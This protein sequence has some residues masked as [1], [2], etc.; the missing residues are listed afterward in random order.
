MNNEFSAELTRF[1]NFAKNKIDELL[2]NGVEGDSVTN[3]ISILSDYNKRFTF[4][5]FNT[6]FFKN[7]LEE[8]NKNRPEEA[9]RIIELVERLKNDYFQEIF[10]FSLSRD[11]LKE[12]INNTNPKRLSRQELVL[13]IQ[14]DEEI[15]KKIQKLHTDY[16]QI[17]DLISQNLS[18]SQKQLFSNLISTL[19][20]DP[21]FEDLNYDYILK[22]LNYETFDINDSLDIQCVQLFNN[23]YNY[24]NDLFIEEILEINRLLNEE[25]IIN[26]T[27][28]M[29]QVFS[30]VRNGSSLAEIWMKENSF[31]L[32]I[33]QT[34]LCIKDVFL[35]LIY[36]DSCSV[37]FITTWSDALIYLFYMIISGFIGAFL[38]DFVKK[39]YFILHIKF[40]WNDL[41]NNIFISTIKNYAFTSFPNF[42]IVSKIRSEL[43][44]E[45][46]KSNIPFAKDV[47][48]PEPKKPA[49]I[50]LAENMHMSK[51]FN[52]IVGKLKPLI[53]HQKYLAAR[54]RKIILFI[55]G[56]GITSIVTSIF[57]FIY[58]FVYKPNNTNNTN[59]KNRNIQ[60]RIRINF[61][62]IITG[63]TFVG[64]TIFLLTNLINLINTKKDKDSLKN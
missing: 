55:K 46:A 3:C 62:R 54:E 38:L 51:D 48:I 15:C 24:M 49:N 5:L 52:T 1:N 64:G 32:E 6:V 34:Y 63:L 42:S 21:K 33:D 14:N 47:G 40:S 56:L 16:V 10:N 12:Y 17:L 61:Y 2:T 37:A 11:F 31:L 50:P 4:N 25:P 43:L 18:R 58:Y 26:F 20:F 53:E 9:K 35:S 36:T 23:S 28:L 59:N 19:E 44:K 41:L 13:K 29:N 8:L 60:S 27:Y 45:R 22:R 30:E 39:I 57:S 7:F